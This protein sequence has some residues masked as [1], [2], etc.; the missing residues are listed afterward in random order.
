MEGHENNGTEGMRNERTE[1]CRQRGMEDCMDRNRGME[2]MAQMT[3]EWR[4]IADGRA[5]D[6][7][8]DSGQLADGRRD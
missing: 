4:N 3:A 7:Q 5:A 2:G 8:G 1:R 6:E